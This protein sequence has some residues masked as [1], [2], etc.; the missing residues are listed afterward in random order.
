MK[1]NELSSEYIQDKYNE[2]YELAENPSLSELERLAVIHCIGLY[3]VELAMRL[4][5]G[6]ARALTVYDINDKNKDCPIPIGMSIIDR[7]GNG[8]SER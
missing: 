4:D 7:V 1:M 2:W 5:D 8:T 3:G 6:R